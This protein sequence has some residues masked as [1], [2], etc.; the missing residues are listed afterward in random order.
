MLSALEWASV[1]ADRRG[2]SGPRYQ[3]NDARGE[4]TDSDHRGGTIPPFI[5]RWLW[6]DR[7]K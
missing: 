2:I 6:Q 4:G 5:L 7:T 1:N 3:I